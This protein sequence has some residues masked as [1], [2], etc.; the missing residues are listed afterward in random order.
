MGSFRPLD[1]TDTGRPEEMLPRRT[2][3]H[4]RGELF[5]AHLAEVN[6]GG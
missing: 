1:A 4:G 6:N 2:H 5:A 3:G